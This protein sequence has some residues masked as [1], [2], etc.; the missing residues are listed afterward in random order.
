MT[1]IEKIIARLESEAG[2]ELDALKAETEAQREAVLAEYRAKAEQ[3][4]ES[5]IK[6]GKTACALR[7]ERLQSAAD[8][9][10]KKRMLAFKQELVGQV[11]DAAAERIIHLP[12]KDYIS[13]LAAQA[14]KA[15]QTGTEELIF[16]AKDAKEVG[17]EVVK[18]ANAKLGAKGKLSLSAQT[19][20]IPGGVIVKRGDIEANCAVDM[21][22]QLQRAT[23]ASQVAEILFA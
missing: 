14:V 20:K 18:A 19:R 23:L 2:A 16:N 1:G 9:E 3:L 10:A 21:L 8:M 5:N 4:Y 15:A 13:F 7:G 6:S 12:Q 22:V 11:F 17:A